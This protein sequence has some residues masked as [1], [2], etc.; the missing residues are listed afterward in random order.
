MIPG[1]IKKGQGDLTNASGQTGVMSEQA[2]E[3]SEGKYYLQPGVG[4]FRTGGDGGF[5]GNTEEE[6]I[7][8]TSPDSPPASTDE[9]VGGIGDARTETKSTNVG[10][11]IIAGARKIIG[12]GK[13]VVDQCANT[14]R[15]ALKAAGNPNAKKVTQK[16]DLDTPKGTAYNAPSFAAS[17]GGT[18]M[19]K[20]ITQKSKIKKGDM[21]LWKA[22]V[23]KGGIVNKGAITHVGIAADDG[24]KHQ[25]DHNTSKGFHYRPHWDSYGGTSWFAGVRLGESGGMTPSKMGEDDQSS[26]NDPIEPGDPRTS[27]SS[28]SPKVD[29]S[30]PL[31]SFKFSSID[32]KAGTP[33]AGI[34]TAA[35]YE[36][37]LKKNEARKDTPV[38]AEVTP[39][40]T[41]TGQ[42]VKPVD[43]PETKKPER[44]DYTGTSGDADYEKDMKEYNSQQKEEPKITPTDTPEAP[45]QT[46]E[47][48]TPTITPQ[49][50]PTQN[51]GSVE[52]QASYENPGE[53]SPT[54]VP[55]PPP[56]QSS[57]GGGGGKSSTGSTG[58]GN[59]L[60]SY[61][62]AQLLGSLYKVG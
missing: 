58:S 16:G 46:P 47:P 62:E 20:I 59:L 55:L 29:T 37:A 21:L 7:S 40:E 3:I 1:N 22:D 23:D 45:G 57:G 10:D 12:L 19:G 18:D 26:G 38:K 8:N 50:A 28:E 14:T 53:G 32:K 51:I 48:S 2:K 49:K 52:K 33:Y 24:L 25:Y 31:N 13:G 5:V 6:A 44:S 9:S 61:Y 11:L 60:N 4:Y 34:S 17:F 35:D 27:L 30:I 42:D 39:T 36:K 15:A 54:I 56:Q 41:M 43:P